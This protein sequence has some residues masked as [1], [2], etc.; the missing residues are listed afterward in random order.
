MLAQ[1][2]TAVF[3]AAT[4]VAASGAMAQSRPATVVPGGSPTSAE[5]RDSDDVLEDG[6]FY[7]CHPLDVRRGQVVQIVMASTDFDAFLMVGKGASCRSMAGFKTDD[8]SGGGSQGLDAQVTVAVDDDGPWWVRA[9][10]V[11]RTQVGAYVLHTTLVPAVLGEEVRRMN[12]GR[13]VIRMGEIV[14]DRLTE[15]S[16][17]TA[18]G[19]HFRCHDFV[20]EGSMVTEILLNSG[21]FDSY[22]TVK[23]GGCPGGRLIAEND[24]FDDT[25]DSRIRRRLAPGPYAVVVSTVDGHATGDYLLTLSIG[26][27]ED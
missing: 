14:A 4:L 16:P 17:Q 10:G 7:R 19:V 5:L 20:A 3:A 25:L 8:D 24:D 15:Q 6:S 1:H 21:D 26:G 23:A 18:D 27:I 11:N 9:S 2:V 13:D 12:G 22:L